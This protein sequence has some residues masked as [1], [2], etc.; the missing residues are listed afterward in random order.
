MCTREAEIHFVI[1]NRAAVSQDIMQILETRTFCRRSTPA[2]ELRLEQLQCIRLVIRV[3]I[4]FNANLQ[5][6][7]NLHTRKP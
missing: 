3:C 2:I 6:Q 5:I 7:Q 1:E 4:L